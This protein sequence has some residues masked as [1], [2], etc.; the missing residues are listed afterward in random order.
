MLIRRKEYEWHKKVSLH[1]FIRG[2]WV[3]LHL[4]LCFCWC[5]W[6]WC[7]LGSKYQC[8]GMLHIYSNLLVIPLSK[9]AKESLSTRPAAIIISYNLFPFG[10]APRRQVGM[11]EPFLPKAGLKGQ[12]AWRWSSSLQMTH[13]N[14]GR[15]LS[16][17]LEQCGKSWHCLH[18]IIFVQVIALWP[19]YRPHSW[20]RPNRPSPRCFLVRSGWWNYPV[21]HPDCLD[22]LP[23]HNLWALCGF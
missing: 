21:A 6:F 3:C 11:S 19:S 14:L 2:F 17:L 12:L 15:N 16:H 22:V 9:R 18:V 8:P 1:D 7:C 13:P 4:Y 23:G 20:D 5:L 10:R